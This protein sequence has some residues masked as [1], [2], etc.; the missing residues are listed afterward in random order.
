MSQGIGAYFS[1]SRVRPVMPPQQGAGPVRPT[2]GV[3][4]YY[5]PSPL[6]P[7]MPP[8]QGA[9]PIQ[10][11]GLGQAPGVGSFVFLAALMALG[12]FLLAQGA[13]R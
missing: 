11:A 12:V 2:A 8:Q 4:A 6:R 13:K 3:G 5:S 9:G 7:V 10:A 1:P